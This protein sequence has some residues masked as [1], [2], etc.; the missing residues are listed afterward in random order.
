MKIQRQR[1]ERGA[2]SIV[3]VVLIAPVLLLVLMFIVQFA[4]VAHA[5]SV[6]EAAA[7]QGAVVARRADG[8]QGGAQAEAV[9]YLDRLGPKMLTTRSVLA[10]RTPEIAT[11]TVTGTVI[12]LVPG[13]HPKVKETSSGPVER[14]VPPVEQAP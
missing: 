3:Q 10:S 12:S 6:V 2:T 4:L 13:V 8:T 1:D 14:Y 11:V 9:K 5:R 7:E